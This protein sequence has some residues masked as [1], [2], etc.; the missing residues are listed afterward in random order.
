MKNKIMVFVLACVLCG[1]VSARDW[2]DYSKVTRLRI[3]DG[4]VVDF[5]LSENVLGTATCQT[6]ITNFALDLVGAQN[7]DV[8]ASMILAAQMSNKKIRV[9]P[10]PTEICLGGA[11]LVGSIEFED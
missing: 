7:P 3:N 8:V 9:L 4:N 5:V 10:S 11:A 6:N 1:S 2:S